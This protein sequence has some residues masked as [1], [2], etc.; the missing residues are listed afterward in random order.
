[1]REEQAVRPDDAGLRDLL[2]T[3]H[4]YGHRKMDAEHELVVQRHNHTDDGRPGIPYVILRLPDVLGPRD[5]T[6]RFWSA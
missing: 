4:Q 6:Y 3:H 5:T 1:V 2:N